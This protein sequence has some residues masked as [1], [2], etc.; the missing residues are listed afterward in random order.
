MDLADWIGA[1]EEVAADAL[2]PEQ[3]M[4]REA[5]GQLLWPAASS[6]AAPSPL[7]NNLALGCWSQWQRDGRWWGQQRW[8]ESCQSWI[9]PS[10]GPRVL[11]G[12]QHGASWHRQQGW[13][14]QGPS[15]PASGTRT[16]TYS[17]VDFAAKEPQGNHESAVEGLRVLS[18][19]ISLQVKITNYISF[20]SFKVKTFF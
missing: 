6:S 16:K 8:L 19:L 1:A 15:L 17:W 3:E 14:R 18:L 2:C 10:S 20:I 12:A 4:Q 9:L 11:G 7:I 5:Q 13:M